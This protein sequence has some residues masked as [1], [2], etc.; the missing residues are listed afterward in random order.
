MYLGRGDGGAEEV[1][2][3]KI[4][5]LPDPLTA[6][7]PFFAKAPSHGNMLLHITGGISKSQ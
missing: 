1:G 3:E 7:V 2:G 6:A 5:E 4:S